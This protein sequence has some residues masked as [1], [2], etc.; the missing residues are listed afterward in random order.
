M[1]NTAFSG[2]ALVQFVPSVSGMTTPALS[3]TGWAANEKRLDGD[4]MFVGLMYAGT[5]GPRLYT[6]VNG[7]AGIV[8]PE[9]LHAAMAL[10]NDALPDEHPG[11]IVRSDLAECGPLVAAKLEAMLRPH[12]ATP[13]TRIVPDAMLPD[14][15]RNWNALTAVRLS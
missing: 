3:D 9:L 2:V 15:N 5:T 11:K 13:Y 1:R 10:A 6:S 8:R 14:E 7:H 12:F 4:D